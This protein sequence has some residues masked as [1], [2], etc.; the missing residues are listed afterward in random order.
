TRLVVAAFHYVTHRAADAVCHLWCNPSP[1]DGSQPDLLISQ[2]NEAG[3]VI[4]R[5]A[6]NSKAAEQLNSWL[7]SFEGQFG[8]MSDITF[9][10][11]MHSLLLLYK[12]EREKDIK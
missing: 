3:E 10:F 6:Y 12:E 8:Q 4:L 1:M 7:T 5:C 9:D 2:V 11:F